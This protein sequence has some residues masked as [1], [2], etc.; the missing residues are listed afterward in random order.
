MRWASPIH[1][2]RNLV[3][4][5]DA[6]AF[7]CHDFFRMV[8][9][10]ANVF[11]AEVDENLR[12]DAAFVLHHTL[13]GRLAIQLAARMKMNLRQGSGLRR[14]L[15]AEASAGMVQIEKDPAFFPFDG[16]ERTTDQL[17]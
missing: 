2:Y 13:T 14:C 7:E 4:N 5:V 3:G 6:V 15:D 9:K 11:E 10:D 1:I 17:C 12:A 8:G 16:R